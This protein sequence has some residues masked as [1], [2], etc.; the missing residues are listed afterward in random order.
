MAAN[1][2][3]LIVFLSDITLPSLKLVQNL[4]RP[5]HDKR[6]GI[7]HRLGVDEFARRFPVDAA[8]LVAYAGHIGIIRPFSGESD[9]LKKLLGKLLRLDKTNANWRH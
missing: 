4:L 6:Y 3:R 5:D 8:P 7:D 1:T 9:R 2:T